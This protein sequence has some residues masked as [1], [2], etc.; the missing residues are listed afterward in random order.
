MVESGMMY[1]LYLIAH[2]ILALIWLG[3][4]IYLDFTVLSGFNK[5]TTEGK[6]TKIVRIRSLSDRTEMIASFFLPLV[7]V[8][9]II[10]R[11]FWLKVG[12][13]HGKILLALIAIGLYHASRGVLKKLEAALDEG[14]PT[15]GSSNNITV[16]GL[17]KRYV[18][19]RMIVLIFLVSTV[20]M[21]VS[22]KGVISTFFLIS[23]WL[24]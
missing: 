15:V 13:M 17:Q 23:S 9:M 14:S 21:I 3:A 24:G 1:N 19:F 4:A 7:G 8:L 20:A 6:K 18:M 12:V 2:F 22:Y 10:D 11:T 16:E 5:A